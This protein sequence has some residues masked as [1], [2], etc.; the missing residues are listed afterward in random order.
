MEGKHAEI[1]NAIAEMLEDDALKLV[2]EFI[3]GGGDAQKVLDMC[4]EAM[5]IVGS[6]FEKGEY[7]LPELMMAGEMLEQI[8]AKVKPLLAGGKGAEV[9]TAGTVVIGTVKGDLH[10]IGKNIVVFMLEVNGYKV[11]DLG[12]DVPAEKF[13]DKLRE[14][15]PPV[16]A[17]SGFLTLAFDSMKETIKAIADAGLRDSVKIMI[18]G[19][20]IDETVRSYT[21]ADAYGLNAMGAVTLCRAWI[22]A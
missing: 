16:L 7:F 3:A 9:K 10:D 19:G 6:R 1:V 20:Q 18:G 4:R 2:D 22:P 12:I 8:G 11:I 13:I 21:G 15:K 17:L 5:D 14:V